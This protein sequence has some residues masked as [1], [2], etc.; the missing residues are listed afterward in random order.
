[1]RSWHRR[2]CC[3][4]M[5]SALSPVDAGDRL[6]VPVCEVA[7]GVAPPIAFSSSS[8]S[9]VSCVLKRCLLRLE[10]THGKHL[11][12][13]AIQAFCRCALLQK[14]CVSLLYDA[15]PLVVNRRHIMRDCLVLCLDVRSY[16]RALGA[17][18]ATAGHRTRVLLDVVVTLG[19]RH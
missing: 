5:L 17:A 16:V 3:V 8:D 2:H 18:V 6:D 12:V 1:M 19:M 14:Y 4:T 10:R 13:T 15:L 7:G 9:S 11:A